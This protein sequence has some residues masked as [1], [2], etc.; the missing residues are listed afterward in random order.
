MSVTVKDD[1][2]R[3]LVFKYDTNTRGTKTFS[4]QSD[5]IK[6]HLQHPSNNM[7]FSYEVS[8]VMRK[9]IVCDFEQFWNSYKVIPMQNKNFYQIIAEGT[10]LK[11][12]MDLEFWRQ[13]NRDKDGD[14]MRDLLISLVDKSINNLYNRDGSTRGLIILE[15]SNE[16]KFSNHLIFPSIIFKDILHCGQFVTQLISSLSETEQ[17]ILQVQARD[18]NDYKNIIDTSVYTKNRHLRV[19]LSSKF[20]EQRP[21][22]CLNSESFPASTIEERNKS[23]LCESL[24]VNI[25][26][27]NRKDDLYCSGPKEAANPENSIGQGLSPLSASS[28][29]KNIDQLVESLARPGKIRKIVY[30]DEKKT[31]RYDITGNKFC[32]T[33]GGSH[34]KNNIYFKYFANRNK[35]IQDCYSQICNLKKVVEIDID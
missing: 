9:F 20:G 2:R 34:S 18:G 29:Y 8:K 24:V 3:F 15:S 4:K 19:Y 22:N 35:L 31:V 16:D 14:T 27:T 11:L 23:I 12:F 25:R 28:P 10:P 17:K 6:F 30:N 1:E 5:A 33:K 21:L 26:S 32:R 13:Q 7:V